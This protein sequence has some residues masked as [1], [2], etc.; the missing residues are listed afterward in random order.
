MDKPNSILSKIVLG[1]FFLCL[2]TAVQAQHIFKG[3]IVDFENQ[4]P[5]P[6]ATV[7][8]TNTTFGVSA[9]ENGSFSISIPDGNY[10][11][12]VRMLGYSHLTYKIQTD[13]LPAQG[14]KFMLDREEEELETVE[15][16]TERDPAWYRNLELFKS[17][18]LGTSKNGKNCIIENDKVLRIDDQ[19]EPGLLQ[20]NATEPLKIHNPLL[21]Y[22][23]DYSLV[24]FKFKR[25]QGYVFYGGYSL[26]IPDSTLS[27][28]KLRK[29]KKQREIAYHGSMQHLIRSMY[30]GN[31]SE[32]GFTIRKLYRMPNPNDSSKFIDQVES[33]PIAVDKLVQRNAAGKVFLAFE[34]YLYIT[35]SKEKESAEYRGTATSGPAGPQVSLMHLETD[36]MEIYANGSYADPY[37]ILVEG[38]IAWER[39]GDLL[40]MDYK[41]EAGSN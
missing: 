15:V 9:D 37:G 39:V 41:P 26:F 36:S 23:I 21:G 3:S 31:T 34:D 2:H 40:P 22:Y 32:Q 35:F 29:A 4:E 33:K 25:S 27:K 16:E 20:V 12:I 24:D 18:F 28:R 1:L 6:Y 7:F 5:V 8:L 13:N 17:Y 38:Y 10:E 19:S 11:V 14:F 30:E